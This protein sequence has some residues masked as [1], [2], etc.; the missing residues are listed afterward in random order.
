M[1]QIRAKTCKIRRGIV[2]CVCSFYDNDEI[3]LQ[4]EWKNVKRIAALTNPHVS[5]WLDSFAYLTSL[6]V[7]QGALTSKVDVLDEPD[8]VSAR[9]VGPEALIFLSL[10]VTRCRRKSCPINFRRPTSPKFNYPPSPPSIT[11]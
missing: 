1:R 11:V 8:M 5:P 2:D 9:V 3:C 7:W 4:I 6:E 10:I